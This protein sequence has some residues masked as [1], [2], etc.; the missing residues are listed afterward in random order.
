MRNN[1]L[2]AEKCIFATESRADKC[3]YIP[4]L[5]AEKCNK[6]YGKDLYYNNL[7]SGRIEKAESH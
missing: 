7:Q 6:Q 3:S 2:C 4:H 5:C 1:I